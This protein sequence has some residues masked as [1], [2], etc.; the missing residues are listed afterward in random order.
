MLAYEQPHKSSIGYLL[1]DSHREVVAD[2]VNAMILLRNPKATDPQVWSRS[3][4]ERLLRQLT[5]SCLVKR[6]MEEDQGE[7]FHLH[8]VLNSSD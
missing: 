8:K 7:A 1:E 6:Q 4:L 3:D 2:T 5:A